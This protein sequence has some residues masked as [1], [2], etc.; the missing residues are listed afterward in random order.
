MGVMRH[1]AVL[2]AVL[3]L[4]PMGGVA[5]KPLQAE[6]CQ[7]L[8]AEHVALR[9]QGVEKKM[10]NGPRWAKANLSDDDI[11]RIKR[12]LMLQDHIKFRCFPEKKKEEEEIVKTV[13]A[14]KPPLHVPLPLRKT[15]P[16]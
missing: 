5:A 16:Q 13:R 6:T 11:S 8:K 4:W 12:Y 7:V 10:K 2:G 1:W 3:I 15:L 9:E 14:A